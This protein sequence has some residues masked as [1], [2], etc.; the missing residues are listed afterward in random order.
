MDLVH[1]LDVTSPEFDPG[2]PD[3]AAARAAC[4]R[5]DTPLGP[6]VLRH[7]DVLALLRDRRFGHDKG[8]R[9]L[10]GR[11]PAKQAEGESHLR[12]TRQR[13]MAAGEDQSQ[14]VVGDRILIGWVRS[15]EIGRR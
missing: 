7:E 6:A 14:A 4:W 10:C 8:A 2:G 5:A 3:V 11:Q 1:H 15:V 13:R 9:D 12:G